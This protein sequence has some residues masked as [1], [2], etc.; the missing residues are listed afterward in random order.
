VYHPTGQYLVYLK[1]LGYT[2][3]HLITWEGE[4]LGRLIPGITRLKVH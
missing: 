3:A 4:D 2:A 1:G